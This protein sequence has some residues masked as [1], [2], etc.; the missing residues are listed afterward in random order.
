M[1]R[2]FLRNDFDTG[3]K[4]ALSYKQGMIRRV[5]TIAAPNLG[6]PIA[7][8]FRKKFADIG[9]MWQNWEAKSW[10]EGMG[11]GILSL[12][13]GT[14]KAD[15]ALEDVSINSSLIAQLGY[16]AIPFHSIYGKVASDKEKIAGLFDSI[17]NNDTV[18][19]KQ[20]TWLPKQ[21]IETLIGENGAAISAGLQLFSDQ[22]RFQEL[23]TTLFNGEDHDIVVSEKS[24][25]DIFPEYARTAFEGL[26]THNHIM[27]TTQD[28][29]SSRVLELLKGDTSSF[30]ISSGVSTAQYDRAFDEYVTEIEPRLRASDEDLSE[31]FDD[32]LS[33]EASEPV[34]EP[35]RGAAGEEQYQNIEIA[36]SSSQVFSD[37][38]CVLLEY[39]GDAAKFFNM[40]GSKANSFTQSLQF[41]DSTSGIV[42]LTYFTTLNGNLKISKT[43][44]IAITPQLSGV[45][46]IKFTS[47][48]LYI[49]AGDE[50]KLEL[51]AQTSKGNYDIAAPL[52]GITTW[53]VGDP[54]V[55]SISET[56]YVSG[57]K[58]GTT[59]LTA[60]A[61]GYTASITV[62]VLP[63]V[64]SSSNSEQTPA[65]DNPGSSSGGCN[66]GFG[67][68]IVLSGC[69][70]IMKKR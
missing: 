51:L 27:L 16:P 14:S 63:A 6:T 45:K 69:A 65:Y 11:W 5:V 28:D 48:K 56:G 21:F 46:G 55:A 25:A 50:V 44:Q 41:D 24:A 40:Q 32:D 10:W 54:E 62:E 2:Q 39:P 60:K 33:L 59:V 52:L 23:F 19:I 17:I 15:D 38:I 20:L 61:E 12:F 9:E 1:A 8:F 43:E 35:G 4:S 30:M 66:A 31:F 70:I 13:A 68:L 37:D 47:S 34:N 18:K 26:E 22:A 57:L 29:V 49:Y 53:T 36:G 67:A 42:K 7:S 58:E 64:S 3:N